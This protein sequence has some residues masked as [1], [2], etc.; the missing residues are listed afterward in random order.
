MCF[1]FDILDIYDGLLFM[2][3]EE[4]EDIDVVLKLLED[5]CVGEMNEMYEWY[6]FNKCD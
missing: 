1:G 4:K 2:I 5:Y 6:V 3:E